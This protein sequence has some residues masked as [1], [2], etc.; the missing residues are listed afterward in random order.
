MYRPLILLLTFIVILPCFVKAKGIEPDRKKLKTPPRIIR[1]CCAFGSD[2]G[3]IGLPFIRYTEATSIEK[4]GR[5]QYLGSKDEANGIVYTCRGGFIDLGHLRDQADWTA[6]LYYQINEH[7][8]QQFTVKLGR[9]GGVKKLS[10]DVP[11]DMSAH[12][13]RQLAGRIAY[14]LS[15]WHEIVTWYGVSS[16]P[17]VPE[18]YSSFSIED[19][20]SNLLGIHLGMQAL[21]S[22]DDFESA[23]TR[24][25]AES[26]L[27]LGAVDSEAETLEAM[28]KVEDEW[29]TRDKKLPSRKILKVRDIADYTGASPLI[30][31]QW[32]TADDPVHLAMPMLTDQQEELTAFYSLNLK[33]RGKMYLRYRNAVERSRIITEEEF[34]NL[35]EHIGEEEQLMSESDRLKEERRQQRRKKG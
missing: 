10:F 6:W 17:L 12:D 7:A 23:M 26:L 27:E 35:L 14:D 5:H 20:Y 33:L 32:C 3:V 13:R 11:S 25:V 8:G 31:P 24:L 4:I 30:V 2:V 18:R 9:E 15:V 16:V 19:D 34:Q 1:T 28:E 29:W 21:A 22:D